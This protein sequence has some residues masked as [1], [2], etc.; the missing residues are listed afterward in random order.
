[1]KSLIIFI[2]FSAALVPFIKLKRMPDVFIKQ[3]DS[4]MCVGR[5]TAQNYK[6]AYEQEKD[7]LLDNIHHVGDNHCVIF[8]ENRQYRITPIESKEMCFTRCQTNN[9]FTCK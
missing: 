7:Y 5:I 6:T 4:I 3:S 9:T 1:M 2:V 8:V